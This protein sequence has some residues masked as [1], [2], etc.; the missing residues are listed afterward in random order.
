M[1][2]RKKNTQRS[3]RARKLANTLPRDAKGRFLPKGSKNLFRKRRGRSVPRKPNTKRRRRRVRSVPATR[4]RRKTS[5]NM[6]SRTGGSGDVKPQLMT[7]SS[8][9]STAPD[10]YVTAL[11]SLPVPRF[12]AQK[13]KATI[14]ELLS[15][16]WYVNIGDML[17]SLATSWAW[18]STIQGRVNAEVSN[19][20]TLNEDIGNAR[21]FALVVRSRAFVTSGMQT[22]HMPVHVDLTDNNGNGILIAT[23]RIQVT[24]GNFGG[25]TGGESIAKILYRLVN[26]GVQEYVGIIQSQQGSNV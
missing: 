4:R 22:F 5:A 15:V 16:D 11:I 25:T 10:D 7:V 21:N 1:P 12:G 19:L 3:R 24:T 2:K 18:L 8:G 9:S 23:D 6:G 20:A 17:D 26:V 14:F 13:N